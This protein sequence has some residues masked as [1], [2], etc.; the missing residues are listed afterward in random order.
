M[1]LMRVNGI[2]KK[3]N[4]MRI[5]ITTTKVIENY[6]CLEKFVLAFNDVTKMMCQDMDEAIENETMF[7]NIFSTLNPF[8]EV[9]NIRG[10]EEVVPEGCRFIYDGSN[11]VYML[12]M[13]GYS[14][15]VLIDPSVLVVDEKMNVVGMFNVNDETKTISFNC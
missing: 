15:E 2:I 1:I 6:K 10:Y 7:I 5:N 3:S 14:E 8:R 9:T 11:I 4:N 12:S 13:V